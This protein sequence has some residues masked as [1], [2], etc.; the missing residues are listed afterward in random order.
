MRER[1][2][3]FNEEEMNWYKRAQAILDLSR[4]T[5]SKDEDKQFEVAKTYFG[6]GHGDYIEKEGVNP[7]FQIWILLNGMIEKSEVFV[8][9][10]ETGSAPNEKSHNM[11]WG[12]EK[13]AIS[14]KGRYEIQTGRLSVVKPDR[15]RFRN[16]PDVVMS[17]IKDAFPRAKEIV[18]F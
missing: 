10:E 4:D 2:S 17:K 16:I 15:Q 11:I 7:D 18:V 5:N 13:E 8:V 14:Y 6:L 12:R 3:L 1:P 9:D